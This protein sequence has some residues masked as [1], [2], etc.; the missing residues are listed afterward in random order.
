MVCWCRPRLLFESGSC[1]PQT[2]A[3][4]LLFNCENSDIL[5]FWGGELAPWAEY[6][7]GGEAQS[8]AAMDP[9]VRLAADERAVTLVPEDQH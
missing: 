3:A 1:P 7:Y 5:P 6:G 9:N 4:R 2:R 8:S